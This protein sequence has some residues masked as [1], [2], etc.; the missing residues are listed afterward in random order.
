MALLDVR[1]GLALQILDFLHG[2]VQI[3]V[4][5]EVLE[6]ASRLLPGPALSAGQ[7]ERDALCKGSECLYRSLFSLPDR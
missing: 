7:S 1:V 4:R 3:G 5:R 6:S 2:G